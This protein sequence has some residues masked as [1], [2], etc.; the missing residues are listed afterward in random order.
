MMIYFL[1]YLSSCRH[2]GETA[3]Q[4]MVARS[5][6]SGAM[7]SLKPAEKN[8]LVLPFL[9][10][11]VLWQAILSVPWLGHASLQ[12]PFQLSQSV[13]S[14]LSLPPSYK[15][16]SHPGLETTV[17]S[18]KLVVFYVHQHHSEMHALSALHPS[19]IQP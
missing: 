9:G 10:S 5:P 11:D 7:F 14:C 2:L 3:V 15:D 16:T 19:G 1:Y 4:V 8:P 6:N 17:N 12:S 13:L 18:S